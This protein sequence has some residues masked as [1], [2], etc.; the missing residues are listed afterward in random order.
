MLRVVAAL[1][2]MPVYSCSRRPEADRAGAATYVD[3]ATCSG[4]HQAIARTYG[5]TGM[6]RSFQRVGP[7]AVLAAGGAYF[8]KASRRHYEMKVRNGQV[9]QRRYQKAANGAEVN[10]VE[11]EIHYVLG[12][13][14]HTRSYLHRTADGRIRLLPLAWYSERGGFWAMNPGYDRPDHQDFRRVIT[15]D[16]MFCHNGYPRLDRDPR[17]GDDAI[18]PEKL[19]EGIDCQRCHG[20]G[21]GH[22]RAAS[23]KAPVEQVRKLIVNPKRLPA[24]RQLEVCLQCHLETTSRTLPYSVIR[25]D[26]GFFSYRPGEP[27][28]NYMLHFDHAAGTGHDDKFE[29]AHQGYRLHKSACFQ[30]SEAM[31]CTTCHNPHA[32]QPAA[33]FRGVCLSCHEAAHRRGGDCLSC[34]MPKRRTDDVIH[35]VMT[36]HLIQR[37][38]PA[39]DLL[40]PLAERHDDARSAYRGEVVPYYPV[41]PRDELY[42]AV[43]Q[44]VEGS[45]LAGGIPRL[46]AAIRRS[47]PT[48]T[49]FHFELAEAYWKNGEGDKAIAAYREA[50]RRRPDLLPAIRN[51]GAALMESGRLVEAAAVLER[52]PED[53]AALSNLG[54][55]Y[56]RL[57]RSD[58]MAVVG[59]A[60]EKNPDSPEAN[61]GL[62]HA[63]LAANDL[64]G[65]AG[66]FRE[67]VRTKPDDAEARYNLGST[68]ARLGQAEEAA[69]EL[70][71][72]VRLDPK[73]ADAYNNL[74]M[75]AAMRGD[76]REAIRQFRAALVADPAHEA[77]RKNLVLAESAR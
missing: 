49:M 53:A 54:Q 21:A 11:K 30:K 36:D 50:L 45:N 2:L 34:H 14:N 37:H 76:R 44:V 27:L 65:A 68:L 63:L 72:A 5:D 33:D 69:S 38:K 64:P 77:A 24:A 56:R 22:V 48:E 18:F 32:R 8:H 16:C 12:S 6:G 25:Y 41:R 55:V 26:R 42:V 62:G 58:A 75:I 20:P 46:E 28:E 51:L 73:L 10:V 1:L 43:A 7:G 52:A 15:H 23:S 35:V 19:P 66:A 29:I 17:H 74:G 47:Q 61:A 67:A 70:G 71:E 39:R 57:G 59:R 4:C 3:A 13:G 31:T 9:V 40:A 60:V